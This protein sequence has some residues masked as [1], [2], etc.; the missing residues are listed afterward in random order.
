MAPVAGEFADVVAGLEFGEPALTVGSGVDDPAYFTAQLTGTVRFADSVDRLHRDGVR[1]FLEISPRSVLGALIPDCVPE[2]VLIAPASRRPAGEVAGVLEAAGRLWVSGLPIRWTAVLDGRGYRWADLPTYAFDHTRHWLTTRAYLA[3]S[4]LAGGGTHPFIENSTDR[5]AGALLLTGRLSA[6][7]LAGHRVG[8]NVLV[9]GTAFVELALA[10]G[11]AAGAPEVREL[12]LTAPLPWAPEGVGVRVTVDAPGNSGNLPFTIHARTG[13]AD[14]WA[15]HATGLLAASTAEPAEPSGPARPGSGEPIGLDGFYEELA[16][17]GLAYEGAFR[18]L[19][20]ARRDGGG[21]VAEVSLPGNL[22]GDGFHL[23]PALADAALHAIFLLRGEQDEAALPH[24]WRDVVVHAPGATAVTARVEPAGPDTYALH[25]SAADGTPVAEIG[26]IVLRRTT[27]PPPGADALFRLA[28]R[29][30][31]D[32]RPRRADAVVHRVEQTDVREAV[33]AVLARLQEHLDDPR[34]LVVLTRG[35]LAGAAVGGLVRSAQSESPGSVLLGEAADENLVLGAGEPEIRVIDGQVFVPRLVRVPVEPA[36]GDFVPGGTVLLTGAG[37]A[38]AHH[39]A[40]HLVAGRGVKELL[41]AGRRG[42]DAPGVGTLIAELERLGARVTAYACDLSDRD[43]VAALIDGRDITGIVHTAGLVDDG[44][45]ALL[46]PERIG[47]VFAPKVDAVR[48]LHEL[49]GDVSRFVVF[50]SAAG[51]FG[52][53]G[54]GNYAAANAFLDALMAERRSAGRAGQ[55]LAWG[56]W[57]EGM[58]GGHGGLTVAEGLALFD[59]ATARDEPVLVPIRLERGRDEVPP[60]LREVVAARGRAGQDPD[61][62][63]RDLAGLDPA[64]RE[65][66]LLDL[67]RRRAAAVLGHAGPDDIA[68]DRDFLESGFDSLT[69]MELRAELNAATGLTL[70]SMVVFDCRT[71]QGLARL[72]AT[73]VAPA[74]EPAPDAETLS[75][76]FRVAVAGGLLQTGLTLLRA[77]A[78]LR[79]EFAT[80]DR[81]DT[82]HG[83]VRLAEGTAE[84]M[85]IFLSTPM[86]TAG[87]HQYARIAGHLRGKRTVLALPVVGFEAAE[88]L[89]ATVEAALDAMT[90]SVGRAA[91]D[92]PYVLA[93]YSSGGLFAQAVAG[94]LERE[95]HGPQGVVLLD[96][97]RI[98]DDDKEDVFGRLAAGLLDAES[99]FGGFTAARLTGMSRYLDLMPAVPLDDIATPVL[100]VRPAELFYTPQDAEQVWQADWDSAESVVTVP[101]NHFTLV[102]DDAA[103][104]AAA[105]ESWLTR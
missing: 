28:W 31:P 51:V 62:V 66:Y 71:A 69:A 17:A 60:L 50:S 73:E 22:S 105:I 52:N 65:A 80:T 46:T 74:P 72:L 15:I 16:E 23:Q 67:V 98:E 87:V 70:P 102:E 39:L 92:R 1:R 61:P 35:D 104:T 55:S 37:G 79:P 12:T 83:P 34:P 4:W 42:P 93:G 32:V 18:G 25:L 75:D 77:A 85:L 84:T 26:A 19:R 9:P 6:S 58:G 48:H 29:P 89:P 68:P 2:E 33:D 90:M 41:L 82:V 76:L 56:R 81:L 47:R 53:P 96:T 64:R 44:I 59:A 8:G 13:P 99:A 78:Q 100:F 38:L 24:V 40:R 94:R 30:L 7:W 86:A 3:D 57:D 14:D 97:Y 10:A 43:A 21:V 63:G 95:G 88:P 49:A 91:G 103:S 45:V 27:V 36:E 54:Q 101:G 5:A 11:A 20:S